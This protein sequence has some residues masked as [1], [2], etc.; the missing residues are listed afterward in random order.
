MDKLFGPDASI[1]E[2]VAATAGLLTGL[3]VIWKFMAAPTIRFIKRLTL[4]LNDWQGHPADETRNVKEQ[5]GL[6][7]RI[8]RIEKEVKYNGGTRT[9]VEAIKEIE[10]ANTEQTSG[11]AF[12]ANRID[13]MADS[14]KDLD[15]KAD[16][17]QKRA[18]ENRENIMLNRANIEENS[19]HIASYESVTEVMVQRIS[20][21]T[22]KN[23][24]V[25]AEI[26]RETGVGISAPSY[27]AEIKLEPAEEDKNGEQPN[28]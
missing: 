14:V 4:F 9:L 1:I 3:A 25:I 13:E 19:K 15:G 8:S 2:S 6:M 24:E 23:T 10:N 20:E 26:I 12:M 21:K 18:D 27:R 22:D 28:H 11:L 5:K 17:L 16:Q 7:E